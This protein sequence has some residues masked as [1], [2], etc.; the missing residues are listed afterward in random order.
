M[1]LKMCFESFVE[2]LTILLIGNIIDQEAVSRCMIF[3]D[4]LIS[5]CL[6]Y[7]RQ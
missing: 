4:T 6:I 5:E 3:K 1:Q 7:D 2:Q